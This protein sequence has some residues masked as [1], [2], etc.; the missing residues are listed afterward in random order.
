MAKK[1]IDNKVS[2]DRVCRTCA[3]Y[4]E[5]R[6]C[7]NPSR[8]IMKAIE[9]A[10]GKIVEVEFVERKTH[11]GEQVYM[12][13]EGC[14]IEESKLDFNVEPIDYWTR[15]EHQYAGMAMQGLLSSGKLNIIMDNS[16]VLPEGIAIMSRDFAHALVEK[17]KEKE[18]RK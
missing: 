15:L 4:D 13:H 9:K 5:A 14:L 11:T 10:T 8:E 6:G 18:E 17:M 12:T 3:L 1:K 16:D 7:S 2:I